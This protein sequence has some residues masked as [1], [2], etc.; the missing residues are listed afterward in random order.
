MYI[1]VYE[2]LNRFLLKLENFGHRFTEK[3]ENSFP[4]LFNREY[5]IARYILQKFEHL[6]SGT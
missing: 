4:R 3:Q 2:I 5:S 6:A 1:N